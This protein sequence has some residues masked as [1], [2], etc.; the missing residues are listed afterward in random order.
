M[1]L[2][3]QLGADN[4]LLLAPMEDVTDISFRL[5]CKRFGADLVYTEFVN[6][7]GLVRSKKPTKTR[8]KMRLHEEERPIGIQIYGGNLN[9]ME[10]AATMA[11]AEQPELL[12]INAGCWV[13]NVAMRGA[14]A[15]LLRDPCTMK[16]MA[17]TIVK[18]V[19][20]PVTLKTRLG[21]DKESINIIEVAKMLEDVGIQVLTVHCRTR[22]QGHN[23]EADWSWIPRIKEAVSIPVVLNGDV[24]SPQA[25]KRA[26][27]ETGCDAVMI[28]RG[29]IA[30]PWIFKETKHYL[31]TGE[32]PPEPTFEEKIKTC[33]EHLRLAVHY[34]GER[35][36]IF[37][38][39]K[40]YSGYLKGVR[41]AKQ[42]RMALMK[43]ES[44]AEAEDL[45]YSFLF[46]QEEI[47]AGEQTPVLAA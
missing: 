9:T 41:H 40:Y 39:R 19:N 23:G 26:F 11:E 42:M 34:K 4:G 17:E 15:G 33:I 1:K 43:P 28:A 24:S 30:N 32:L 13:K 47:G 36:A 3:E 45:L 46:Y 31:A 25:A 10:E 6:A 14:G 18:R 16:S 29:A 2:L 5:M 27:A 12:D 44:L 20:L 7:D 8:L 37:E 38:N 21:W 22:S 35:R